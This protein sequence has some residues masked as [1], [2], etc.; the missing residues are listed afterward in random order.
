MT[1]VKKSNDT[2]TVTLPASTATTALYF[3]KRVVAHG[4]EQEALMHA[5][6]SLASALA[7]PHGTD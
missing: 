7:H 5:Y 1:T 4:T 6:Q 2:H 3:L